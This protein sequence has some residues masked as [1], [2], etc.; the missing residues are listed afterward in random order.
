MHGIVNCVAVAVLAS[1][2]AAAPQGAALGIRGE[3]RPAGCE[4]TEV[5]PDSAAE[6]AGLRVGDIITAID[7]SPTTRF[8]SIARTI[9]RKS[10]G[11]DVRIDYLR[12]SKPFQTTAI[13]KAR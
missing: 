8:E 1:H 11:A 10:V 5:L 4:L 3:D 9:F 7:G 12:G 6:L 2:I 13:L